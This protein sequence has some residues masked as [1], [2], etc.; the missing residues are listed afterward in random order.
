[1]AGD[2]AA[3]SLSTYSVG[4]LDDLS[5]INE[6][7]KCGL[8]A[9][10]LAICARGVGFHWC[11]C[12]PCTCARVCVRVWASA[13]AW[14]SFLS[15]GG[16]SVSAATSNL[17]GDQLD[18]L[19]YSMAPAI[20]EVRRWASLLLLHYCT[21][22]GRLWALLRRVCVTNSRGG[23]RCHA[24]R[25][26][27]P[28]VRCGAAPSSKGA[29]CSVLCSGAGAWGGVVCVCFQLRVSTLRV[30]DVLVVYDDLKPLRPSDIKN[31]TAVFKD[32]S[33]VVDINSINDP[34]LISTL[35]GS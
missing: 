26:M 29:A 4:D 15:S 7:I 25:R 34:T 14:D 12:V 20:D 11:V 13:A 16:Y 3:N 6:A 33:Y 2:S 8:R 32:G 19:V 30:F 24:V 28:L 10:L 35:A 21:M 1:M 18:Y 17:A 23:G 31:L 5:L 9:G 27:P 22:R